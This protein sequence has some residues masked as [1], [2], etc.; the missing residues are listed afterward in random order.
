MLG[1]RLGGVVSEGVLEGCLVRVGGGGVQV[2]EAVC[3]DGVPTAIDFVFL[4]GCGG[5]G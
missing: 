1:S 5:M 3:L 2:G 4:G